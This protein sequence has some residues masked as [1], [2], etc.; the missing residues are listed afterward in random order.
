[1]ARYAHRLIGAKNFCPATPLIVLD[2]LEL[3]ARRRFVVYDHFDLT[4][5]LLRTGILTP[6]INL[7]L[8]RRVVNRKPPLFLHGA[9]QHINH[10]TEQLDEL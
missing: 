8:S 2:D 10:D 6:T 3:K 9:L 4:G 7:S 5:L 1:M